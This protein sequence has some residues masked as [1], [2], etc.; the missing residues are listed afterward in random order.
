MMPVLGN[1]ALRQKITSDCRTLFRVLINDNFTQSELRMRNDLVH[2][3]EDLCAIWPCFS[4]F[5]FSV[6]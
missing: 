5:S 3:R 1:D 2:T 4:L 6:S